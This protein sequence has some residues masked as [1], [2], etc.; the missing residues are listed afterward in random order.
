MIGMT[1]NQFVEKAYYGDEVEFKL[2]G[3]TY[4]MQG[5]CENG[6]YTLTIDYW[7]STDGKEENHDYLLDI[8]C[9]SARQRMLLLEEAKIFNHKTIYDVED[10]IEVVFG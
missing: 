10:N 3:V 8:T 9:S 6:K 4:F 2:D 5:Y 1:L 7:E